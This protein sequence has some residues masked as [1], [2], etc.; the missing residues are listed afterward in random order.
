M[1]HMAAGWIICPILTPLSFVRD[2]TIHQEE[3]LRFRPLQRI[4][5]S[6][7]CVKYSLQRVAKNP[8][9]I[10]INPSPDMMSSIGVARALIDSKIV[11]GIQNRCNLYQS[12]VC[13][14]LAR[15]RAGLIYC[16]EANSVNK[17]ILRVGGTRGAITGMTDEVNWRANP[18]GSKRCTLHLTTIMNRTCQ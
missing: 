17:T 11:C 9:V 12:A 15:V 4:A 1:C 10:E 8:I 6:Q 7:I 13:I 5:A 18:C 14:S 3:W 16:I 2:Q